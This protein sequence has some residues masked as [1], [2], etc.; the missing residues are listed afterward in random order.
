MRDARQH[1]TG[2]G[3]HL[4]LYDGVCGLCNRVNRFVLRHDRNGRFDFAPLQSPTG[5]R[6]LRQLG[7]DPEA[8]DTFY[9]VADYRSG[10]TVL[11]RARAALFVLDSLGAPWRAAAVVRILPAR[12]LDG[13][14]TL[15]ARHRYRV[16]GRFDACPLPRPEDRA[17]FIDT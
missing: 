1:R 16:F 3:R 13:L 9:V 17:R 5:Q 8:L 4:M 2:A 11:S 7:K 10:G 15:V 14:Y 6:F 12:L